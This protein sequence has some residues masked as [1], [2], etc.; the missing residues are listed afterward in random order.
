MFHFLVDIGVVLAFPLGL[1]LLIWLLVRP[2]PERD[3]AAARAWADFYGYTAAAGWQLLCVHDVYERWG[4]GSKAHVSV[5]DDVA[6]GVRDSWFWW[7]DVQPDSVVAVNRIGEG[8]GSHT[9]RDGVLYIGDKYARRSGVQAT[10][11]AVELARARRHWQAGSYQVVRV[12]QR[13]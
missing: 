8:W 1:G 12:E 3:A 10:F 13:W 7:H 9:G 11:G 2:T 6:G 5:Y 4:N